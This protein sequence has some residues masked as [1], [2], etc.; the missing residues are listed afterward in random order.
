M[1]RNHYEVLALSTS[2]TASRSISQPDVKLA[3][4][5]ALLQHHPDK[6]AK[7]SSQPQR[8]KYSV[9]EIT[10][11]YKILSDSDSRSQYDQ[12]LRLQSLQRHRDTAKGY[13]GLETVDLD[14]LQYDGTK[15]L[16]YRSCR[17]GNACGYLVT[18]HELEKEADQGEIIAGC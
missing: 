4:R 8:S 3:Y 2:L 12:T 13:I 11:A 6:S 7:I 16:W 18:E 15:G 1:S 9:D 17:C 10:T 14:D 5:Q